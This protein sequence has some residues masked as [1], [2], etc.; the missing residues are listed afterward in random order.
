MLSVSYK[1]RLLQ[2][3]RAKAASYPSLVSTNDL[4]IHF[5]RAEDDLNGPVRSH[6]EVLGL[7]GLQWLASCYQSSQNPQWPIGL[8]KRDT[9]CIDF[10]NGETHHQDTGR[11]VG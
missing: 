4:N 3:W 7:S 11:Q 8:P 9:R 2:C 6:A 1:A 10:E 5:L